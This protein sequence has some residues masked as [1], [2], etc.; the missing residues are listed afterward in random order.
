MTRGVR[1]MVAS[2]TVLSM[3]GCAWGAT[4]TR[5]PETGSGSI[6]MGTTASGAGDRARA[7][8]LDRG[9]VPDAGAPPS[10]KMPTIRDTTLPNGLRV[11]LVER[12]ALPLVSLELVVRGGASAH[13]ADR[14]GLAALTADMLDEGTGTRS[15][16]DIA[17][18]VDHLGATLT[19]SAGYDASQLHVSVLRK[20]FGEV[21][22]I[23]ADVV[24][25]PTFPETE[26]ERVRRERMARVLQRA[27][28]PAALAEDAFATVLYGPDHAYGASLLGTEES[29]ASITREEVRAFHSARYAPGQSALVVAGDVTPEALDSLLTSAFAGWTGRG[30]DP[31]VLATPGGVTE[32]RIY[33]VDRPGAAQSEIRIGRVAT[34]RRT[35]AYHALVVA[36]TLLGGSFT[37]RLNAKLREEKGYTYGA[38]SWFDLRRYPGPFEAAAAVAT[39][40]T[41]SAVADFVHEIDRMHE[42]ALPPL[43]LARARNFVALRLP[44][45]FET[46]D[47]VVRRI[48]ELAL[49]GIPLSFYDG[50]VEGVEAVEEPGLRAIADEYLRTRAMAIVVVGDRAS[51]EDPL[52]ALGLGPVVLVDAAQPARR[53]S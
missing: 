29:L 18:A 13:P 42:D 31:P 3:A 38:G 17:S 5:D 53:G 27:D 45:R 26:L 10:M 2:W 24:M 19:S 11:V 34:D 32:R 47:D 37:S 9:S 39:P 35:R 52:R 36:N 14:A 16:L 8:A 33:L 12:H 41:D 48:S 44:Q 15:A 23:L 30:E 1:R 46:L 20:H 25:N 28:V 4:Y 7:S 49:Y 40:V 6:E 51:I 22:A 50:Y 21:L 43:E